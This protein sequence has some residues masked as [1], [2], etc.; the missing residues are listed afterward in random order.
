MVPGAWVCEPIFQDNLNY[1]TNH[2]QMVDWRLYIKKHNGTK[3]F[4][5]IYFNVNPEHYHGIRDVIMVYQMRI[6]RF[7]HRSSLQILAMKAIS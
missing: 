5:G 7:N 2:W 1:S 6:N 3:L 4:S